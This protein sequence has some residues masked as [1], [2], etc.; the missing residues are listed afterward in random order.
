MN[1]TCLRVTCICVAAWSLLAVWGRA[2]QVQ[3]EMP[4]PFFAYCVGIGVE[5]AL[6]HAAGPD[7]ACPHAGRVGLRRHGL[8]AASTA[9]SR[10][11]ELEKHKQKLMAVYRH[12]E[13]RSR[14]ARA[15]TRGSRHSFPS[16]PATARWCGSPSAAGSYKPSTR[17]RRR[18]ARSNC[19]GNCPI[20]PGRT[21]CKISLYPHLQCYAQRMEDVVRLAKKVDRPNVGVTFTFCHFLALDD[22]KN[23]DRVLRAGPAVLEHGHH[24]RHRRL[25]R[26]ESFRAGSRRS[27]QGSFDVSRVL[28]SLRKIDYRGPIGM[29][30]LRHPRR[31]PRDS[32]AVDERLEGD[33]RSQTASNHT[34]EVNP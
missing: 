15:T 14:R 13:R 18:A 11:A 17:R 34:N 31:P 4:N 30:C 5:P 24:Q 1:R 29:I 7:G 32:R 25:R 10:L 20:W 21:A 28:A 6:A 27:D 19:C 22:A 3:H 2:A 12:V 16:W 23:I 9:P 26:E 8:G 33:F